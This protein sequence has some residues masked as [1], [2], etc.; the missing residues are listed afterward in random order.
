MKIYKG[1][2]VRWMDYPIFSVCAYII[3]RRRYVV[4]WSYRGQPTSIPLF[5]LSHLLSVCLP[6]RCCKKK[7]QGKAR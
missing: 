4:V 3:C 7:S 5:S 6:V 2:R 1:R